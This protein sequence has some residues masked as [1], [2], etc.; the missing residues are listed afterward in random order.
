MEI[1]SRQEMEKWKAELE[2]ATKI[3]VARIG[4]NQGLDLPMNEA[5]QAAADKISADLSEHMNTAINH[6]VGMQNNM[7]NMHGE[8]MDKIGTAMQML[9]APKRV[10]RGPDGKVMGVEVAA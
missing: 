7:A 2:S 4:A 3:M 5:Q 1:R 6:M 8:T 10:V 9:S